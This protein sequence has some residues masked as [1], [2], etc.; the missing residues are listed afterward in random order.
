M[1]R[2]LNLNEKKRLSALQNLN[3]ADS[4]PDEVLDLITRLTQQ[5]FD[6]PMCLI[7]LVDEHR[8]WFKSKTNMAISQT[9]RDIAFCDH[10]IRSASVMVVNDAE[11][12]PRFSDNPLVTAEKGMR[13]YAGAPLITRKGFAI[14]SLCLIDNQPRDFTVQEIEMLS[15]LAA[16]VIDIIESRSSVGFTDIVTRLPNHQRLMEDIATLIKT[17]DHTPYL[18]ILI[19]TLDTLYA[20]DIGRAIGIPK[21]ENILKDVGSFLRTELN[22]NDKVYSLML[23][24]FALIKRLDEQ[25]ETFRQLEIAA[26]KIQQSITSDIPI[27]VRLHAGYTVFS[28]TSECAET[29]MRQGMSSLHEAISHNRLVMPYQHESDVIQLRAF[30]LLND[31]MATVSSCEDFHL[32]YQP[33]IRLADKKFHGVEALIRWH[34]PTLGIISPSEFIPLAEKT[35]LITPLTNWVI[36]QAVRQI[37]EWQKR[38]AQIQVSINLTANNLVEQDLVQRIHTALIL[39][40][41]SPSMLEI[42]CL[43]TQTLMNNPHAVASLDA[44]RHM[45][46]SIALDDFGSGYSNLNYLQKIPAD[47]LKLDQS[48][49]QGISRDSKSKVIVKSMIDMAHA[50]SYHVVAEGVEDNDTLRCL[51]E[52]QCDSVQGFYYSRPLQH[53]QILEWSKPYI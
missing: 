10:T 27:N 31:L 32:L 12:D 45:G 22:E 20:Y 41:V 8:Q 26:T 48:L 35:P 2:V 44:L 3:I 43:E 17:S 47:T 13:F 37:A 4:N 29:I 46:I 28:S 52:L 11:Q 53:D 24:R 5:I 1:K 14:G 30:N 40:Q 16:I 25:E 33:K 39:H 50:L 6:I 42:E 38:G 51:E 9:A 18:L 21:V 36:T 23:G 7:T 34:H 15:D 49:I 19:D